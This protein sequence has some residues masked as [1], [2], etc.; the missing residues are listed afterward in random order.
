MLHQGDPPWWNA[1][2]WHHPVTRL[3]MCSLHAL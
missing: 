1:T 2:G 3:C